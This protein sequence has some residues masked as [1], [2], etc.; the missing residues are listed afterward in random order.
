[1]RRQTTIKMD[2]T[3]PNESITATT[4]HL[5]HSTVGRL[6]TSALQQF[7]D[8]TLIHP[9]QQQQWQAAVF[10]PTCLW[11]AHPCPRKIDGQGSSLSPH[12][13][14]SGAS[15]TVSSMS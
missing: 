12:Y 15:P 1:M 11:S 7:F 14:F 8:N 2:A 5:L 3:N 6:I 4:S 10:H 9:I 13:S